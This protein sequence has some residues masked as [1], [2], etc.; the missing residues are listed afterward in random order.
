MK[1]VELAN[2]DRLLRKK[3]AAALLACSERTVD[4][5]AD[6]GRLTRV[7][8]RGGVRFRLSEVQAIINGN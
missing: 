7:R 5:D 6:C 3:E 2:N 1:N 4:R 8:V